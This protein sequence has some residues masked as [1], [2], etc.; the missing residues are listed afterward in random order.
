MVKIPNQLGWMSFVLALSAM[1]SLVKLPQAQATTLSAT[2]YPSALEARLATLSSALHQRATATNADLSRPEHPE[3][4]AGFANRS[5]GGSF[6]NTRRG[7]WGDG[8]GGSF[9]NRNP[10]RNGWR[11]GGGFYNRY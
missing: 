2:Q 8:R 7:G 10:W 5:G 11:D 9:V 3:N 6:G 1:G 4:L